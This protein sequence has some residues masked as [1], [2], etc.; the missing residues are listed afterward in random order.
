M[1]I[2]F[3]KIDVEYQPQQATGFRSGATTFN[4]EIVTAQV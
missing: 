1:T 3:R 2:A 4:D